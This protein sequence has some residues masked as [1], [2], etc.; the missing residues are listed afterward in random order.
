MLDTAPL[1]FKS[2]APVDISTLPSMRTTPL[3]LGVRAMLPF[4]VDTIAWPLTSKSPP[5]CGVVSPTRS[6]SP[7]SV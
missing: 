3:P 5:S 6:L 1:F 2:I 4:D 7:N